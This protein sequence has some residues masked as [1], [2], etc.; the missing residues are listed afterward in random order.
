M[1]WAGP[2]LFCELCGQDGNVMA[3]DLTRRDLTRREVD[4]MRR[5]SS[6]WKLLVNPCR[7]HR[8]GVSIS[9]SEAHE[10]LA[11][12]ALEYIQPFFLIL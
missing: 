8:P 11:T 5:F 9:S 6:L 1:M 7:D 4:Q 3:E 10:V 2:Q 12:T